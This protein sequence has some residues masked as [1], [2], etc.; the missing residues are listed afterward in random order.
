MSKKTFSGVLSC[1]HQEKVDELIN[2]A[3]ILSDQEERE[4]LYF[5]AQKIV[6]EDA[7]YIFLYQAETMIPM[8]KEV[9][10]FV[11]NPMLEK[12]FNFDSIYKD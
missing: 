4:K 12:M 3:V 9:K 5:E 1:H 6:M 10:N 11:Y 8:R 2:E 7:P